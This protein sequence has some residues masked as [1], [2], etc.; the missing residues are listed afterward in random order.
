MVFRESLFRSFRSQRIVLPTDKEMDGHALNA[1]KESHALIA[2]KESGG[3][4]F[5]SF[6]LTRTLTQPV[7]RA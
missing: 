1:R 7:R 4:R 2:C 6:P 5:Y 3:K